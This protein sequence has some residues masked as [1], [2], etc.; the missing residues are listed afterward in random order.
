MFHKFY[1]LIELNRFMK[2]KMLSL[3]IIIALVV[4]FGS[5]F[6]G[7]SKDN[8]TINNAVENGTI[9]NQ[10]ELE[11]HNSMD[12]CWVAY[13][14]RVYDI[15]GWLPKH[16]GTAGAILPYCGTA[17]EFEE[18]FTNQHGTTKASMLMKVGVFMGDFKI[19]GDLNNGN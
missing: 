4:I 13:K 3:I 6:L 16:P 2:Y 19:L 17:R 1:K 18:A 10:I 5:F 12:D 15:T 8:K 14:G 7:E 11:V 9:V